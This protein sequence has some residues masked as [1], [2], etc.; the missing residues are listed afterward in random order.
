MKG[1]VPKF[2]Y[3]FI[4]SNSYAPEKILCVNQTAP[5]FTHPVQPLISS[6]T[7]SFANPHDE[8]NPPKGG[9]DVGV[10]VGVGVKDAVGVGVKV[11]ERI[12]VGVGVGTPEYKNHGAEVV[13]VLKN[14]IIILIP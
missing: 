8:T 4:P 10:G 14:S 7:I 12:G 3:A 2:I 6:V 13:S 11:S 9:V 1:K 5:L